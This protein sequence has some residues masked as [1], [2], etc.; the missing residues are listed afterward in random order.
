MGTKQ[1]FGGDWTIEKLDILSSYL[2]FYIAALKNQSFSKIYIDAFAGTGS[3][4]V[5]CKEEVIEGSAKLALKAQNKFDKYIFVERNKR[6][7]K[8]LNNMVAEQFADLAT[9]I[10]VY[11]ADCNS[12]L[13]ELCETINWRNNRAILFLDPYATEVKWETLKAIASTKA[14]DLWYL[15]PLSAANRLMKNDREIE[16]S[17]KA[18]LDMIFGDSGW[19]EEFYKEDPQLS[20]LGDND[21]FIKRV[22]TEALTKYICER[23]KTIFPAVAENPRILYNTK[24][25]PLFLFCFAV[26]NDSPKA[27]GLALK[28]ANHILNYTRK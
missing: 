21:K 5:G 10:A 1:R 25:S 13:Q 15:F 9:R 6:F 7:A 28:G 2:D 24:N 27:T 8:E 4:K 16:P 19:Y 17:W 26:S 20:L 14:I 11:N 18:K 23:L 22:N 12:K 3:I